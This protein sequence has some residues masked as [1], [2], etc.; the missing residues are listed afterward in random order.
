MPNR[1]WRTLLC[2]SLLFPAAGQV[3]VGANEPPRPIPEMVHLREGTFRTQADPSKKIEPRTYTVGGFWIGRYEVTF[4]QF[5]RFCLDTGYYLKRYHGIDRPL[6]PF[7]RAAIVRA[8]HGQGS[9]PAPEA[10]QTEESLLRDYPVIQV[11]WLDAMAYC[12]WLTEKTGIAF[13]LP[14][15][16]EWEYACT[17]GGSEPA[18]V[19]TEELDEV[20]WCDINRRRGVSQTQI[21]PVGQKLPN[22]AD[23]YDMYGNVWEWCLDG[24]EEPGY[25]QAIQEW[26]RVRKTLSPLDMTRTSPVLESVSKLLQG[27]KALRG[28]AWEEPAYRVSPSFRMFYPLN[29]VA[30]RVGF[31][32]LCSE[33]P[34]RVLS[35]NNQPRGQPPAPDP[36]TRP[37]AAGPDAPFQ[38]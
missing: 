37:P 29:Y 7:M 8:A 14:T 38:R 6:A 34:A 4:E 5:D 24:R 22:A 16:V 26:D 31:R 9:G 12:L 33:N 19:S 13:R 15:Q 11:C 30:P 20:A 2:L 28:G 23:L 36:N 21:H 35:G 18:S 32:V 1:R 3:Q 25:P 10:P 17:A 27:P